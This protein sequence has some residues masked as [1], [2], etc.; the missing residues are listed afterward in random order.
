M[1]F[2]SLICDMMF[3]R[4]MRHCHDTKYICE[5]SNSV[6]HSRMLEVSMGGCA[7]TACKPQSQSKQSYSTE[8]QELH[9][10]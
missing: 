10:Q 5:L 9:T 4:F 1:K 2:L 6:P 3:T 7:N 8:I